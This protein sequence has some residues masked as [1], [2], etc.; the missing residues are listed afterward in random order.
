[1]QDV[2]LQFNQTVTL[3]NAN[4]ADKRVLSFNDQAFFPLNG[5]GFGDQG[6]KDGSGNLQN[7]HFTMELHAR[8]SYQGGEVFTFTGDDDLWVF[9][10][11][12]LVVRFFNFVSLNNRSIWE[13]FTGLCLLLSTLM[14]W[15]ALF[16]SLKYKTTKLTSSTPNDT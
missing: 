9:I 6:F 15:L 1:M 3:S 7:F 11:D 13:V 8:F 14:L 4:N 16:R 2:N 12:F 10:N 5:K